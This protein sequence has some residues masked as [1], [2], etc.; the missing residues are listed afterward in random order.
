VNSI[1]EK[2]SVVFLRA[3]EMHCTDEPSL[4]I[5]VL[6]SCL[7]VTMFS[8]RLHIGG[9]CHGL[10]P[11]CE[12][13]RLCGNGCLDA[14]RYVDCSIRRMIKL[15]DNAGAKRSEL[16]VKCFGGADL[17]S[18]K[19]EKPGLVSVGRQNIMIAERL[20]RNEGL[21][22]TKQ[23]V[24]GLRG[25]KIYFYTDTGEV[26]LKRLSRGDNFRDQ[27]AAGTDLRGF[28]HE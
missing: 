5:T 16:E 1:R 25:R 4:V 11:E 24:G 9:I 17:F 13:K 3:G 27:P 28:P 2:P 7:S 26:L 21:K 8:P 20:L 12:N 6:G 18:R 15:F 23:D 14:F 22:I 10:L 19:I